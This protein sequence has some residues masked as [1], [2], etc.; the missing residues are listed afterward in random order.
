LLK[1]LCVGNCCAF[2]LL[3]QVFFFTCGPIYVLLK[4]KQVFKKNVQLV[5]HLKQCTSDIH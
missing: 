1:L 5:L 4:R 3:V 2:V